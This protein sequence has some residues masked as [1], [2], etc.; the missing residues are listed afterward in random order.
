M[1]ESQGDFLCFPYNKNP[2][3]RQQPYTSE[4]K[5]VSICKIKTVAKIVTVLY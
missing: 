4:Y 3:I 2:T 5:A 1:T